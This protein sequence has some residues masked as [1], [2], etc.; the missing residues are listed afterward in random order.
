MYFLRSV[1]IVASFCALCVVRFF[2]D[3]CAYSF[4]ATFY[5]EPVMC[6]K[7]LSIRVWIFPPV[8]PVWWGLIVIRWDALWSFQITRHGASLAL[9]S[10]F[11]VETVPSW[12]LYWFKVNSHSPSSKSVLP[13]FVPTQDWRLLN[14]P[15]ASRKTVDLWS[16]K[17][18]RFDRGCHCSIWSRI[19]SVARTCVYALSDVTVN[20][21]AACD[22]PLPRRCV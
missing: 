8:V 22:V 14:K 18:L 3:T 6:R 9:K 10:S 16:A 1:K 4:Q 21:R 7:E 20:I 19:H 2:V 5:R 11:P 17:F 13:R 12:S 15:S